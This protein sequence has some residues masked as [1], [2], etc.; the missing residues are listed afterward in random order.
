M[1]ASSFPGT[2]PLQ[3]VAFTYKH[4]FSS[5][6][7]PVFS[8]LKHCCLFDRSWSSKWVTSRTFDCLLQWS[9]KV[10]ECPQVKNQI[11]TFL[12]S[13]YLLFNL[14]LSMAPIT[15]VQMTCQ[16]NREDNRA[17]T[18][19]HLPI[20]DRAWGQIPVWIQSQRPH[21]CCCYRAN[22][23]SRWVLWNISS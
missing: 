16:R 7:T 19:C 10:L 22:Q 8:P 20:L 15:N 3:Q 9:F 11:L 18:N 6:I 14:F 5:L 2:K 1:T 4:F 17:Y 21:Q 12:A 23:L 13:Y